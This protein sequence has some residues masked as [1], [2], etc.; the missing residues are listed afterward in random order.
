VERKPKGALDFEEEEKEEVM[1]PAGCL[2]SAAIHAIPAL[3]VACTELY[4]T[5]HPPHREG[6]SRS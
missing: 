5:V 2:S 3:T 1:S 6:S 4:T